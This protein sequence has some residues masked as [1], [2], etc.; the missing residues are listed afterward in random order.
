MIACENEKT[1]I[2]GKHSL[3]ISD[4]VYDELQT[5]NQLPCL[6]FHF[7]SQN[8]VRALWLINNAMINFQKHK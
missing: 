1:D 8:I 7:H 5:W 6:Q 2:L 4:P 3:G